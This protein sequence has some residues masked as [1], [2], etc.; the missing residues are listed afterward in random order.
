MYG[1]T[2]YT[3]QPNA[4]AETSFTSG[5]SKVYYNVPD[6]ATKYFIIKDS[7]GAKGIGSI[8]FSCPTPA[9]ATA[10]PLPTDAPT[11]IPTET[12]I[13]S[14]TPSGY[15]IDWTFTKG[16]GTIS[17][18]T[19]Q[20]EGNEVLYRNTNGH[21]SLSF[22]SGESVQVMFNGS[23]NTGNLIITLEEYQGATT[24]YN[25]SDCG[26]DLSLDTGILYPGGNIT[27][28]GSSYTT[29]GC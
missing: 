22:N 15:T 14:P 3:S 6:G 26:T 2:Y 8:T 23:V 21:G 17:S 13:P 28:S 12:P 11:G 18:M 7:L 24:L 4:Y 10:T 19:I 5:S 9:P 29:G 16:V 1:A 25:S 20:V 27:V